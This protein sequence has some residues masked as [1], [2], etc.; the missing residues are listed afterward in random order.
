MAQC[1]HI[2][3]GTVALDYSTWVVEV[4]STVPDP[5]TARKQLAVDT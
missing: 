2:P 5:L 3:P 1:F 4:L